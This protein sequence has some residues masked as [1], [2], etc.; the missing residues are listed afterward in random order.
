[1]NKSLLI[2]LVAALNGC[3][4]GPDYRAPQPLQVDRF[5]S[6]QTPQAANRAVSTTFWGGFEDPLLQRLIDRTLTANHDLQAAF[7]RYQ[8]AEALL[9]GARRDQW[10]SVT[11]N[12]GV[13]EQKLAEIERADPE[14]DRLELH[15][16]GLAFRWEIDLFGRLARAT[17]AR[18][19]QFEATG[20]D[21]EALQVALVGQLASRYFELRGLQEQLRVAEQNITLQQS[22]LDIV[23][24]RLAA[25]RGT[26][27]DELRGRA[28]LNVT[29]AAIP[30]L[31]A[32]I[33]DNMHRL[34]VLTGS[35][36]AA[37]VAEL[38]EAPTAT[39][40]SAPSTPDLSVGTPGDVLRRRPD[41][42]AA[43][44][45]IAAASA[46]IG[47]ATADLFPRF[48]LDG[49]AGSVATTGSDLFTSGSES[50]LIA[51]G[52]D[53]TF[54]DAAQVRARVDAADAATTAALAEYRQAVLL[55]LEE[56]ETSLAR[57]HYAQTRSGLFR[58]AE[59]AAREAVEQARDR[60]QQGYTSF[61]ELLTA[62]LELSSARDALVQSR[63]F[64]M[65]AMVDVY[66]SIAGPPE[67]RER[68]TSVALADDAVSW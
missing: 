12:A 65:L 26:S 34:A 64:E 62:E 13:S 1:M 60:Y 30:Q 35:A 23:S 18:H 16:T 68:E 9:R 22:S 40:F 28:Q 11:A 36:P 49:L 31:H 46:R 19:A 6:E 56:T 27:F 55:A 5:H 38:E 50:R 25:G 41:I 4:V 66:R 43:E 2:A 53:W 57:H 33:K 47:I 52:V 44:R 61:F 14:V 48:T 7:A 24:A 15:Q 63:T 17:E 42:R 10:P 8:G 45:R 54:L 67:R 29:R 51:L 39:D 20:A 3:A 21:L 59:E 32:R 37:L 58:N